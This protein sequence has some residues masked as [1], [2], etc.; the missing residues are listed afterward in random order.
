MLK[1]QKCIF[2]LII[3]QNRNISF[4]INPMSDGNIYIFSMECT[5]QGNPPST[6]PHSEDGTLFI[7]IHV[8]LVVRL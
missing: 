3:F 5:S 1:N 6:S 8:D 4:N 7:R 2:K